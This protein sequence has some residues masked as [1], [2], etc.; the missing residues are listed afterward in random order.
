M[1][2]QILILPPACLLEAAVKRVF[3]A[4]I[5]LHV[6]HVSL[7]KAELLIYWEIVFQY[8][9]YWAIATRQTV[10]K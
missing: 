10:V 5:W 7:S 2:E 9:K 3:P 1:L 8:V 6:N 4:A